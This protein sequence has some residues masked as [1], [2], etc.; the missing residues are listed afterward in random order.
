MNITTTQ[1]FEAAYCERGMYQKYFG[2][3]KYEC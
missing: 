1:Y 3:Q 2:T